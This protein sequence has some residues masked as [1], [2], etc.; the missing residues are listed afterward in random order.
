MI[1]ADSVN[2][3]CTTCHAEKRGPFVFQHAPVEENCLTCHNPHG[4]NYNKLLSEKV[5]NVC[6]DCH[7]WS[8]HPGT[9]YGGQ[10]AQGGTSPNTRFF[11]RSCMNCHN[12]IHGSNAAGSSGQFFTR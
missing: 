3:L 9:V 4:T 5:P 6:Q 8:R 7:D 1:K 10:G 11:A 2:Q 12:Q